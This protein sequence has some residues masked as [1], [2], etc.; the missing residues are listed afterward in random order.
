[1]RTVLCDD[2]RFNGLIKPAATASVVDGPWA[3][4]DTSAAGSPTV[5]TNNGFMELALDAT[6]EA[7][8][9]CLYF[10][11]QLP[12][13]IDDLVQVDIWA[14]ITASLPA[15]VSAAFGLASARNDAIDSIAAQALFRLIG[16][17]NLLVESDDGTTDK[18]DIATGLT[19]AATL[20]RFTISFK[21]G[22]NSVVGGLSTGGKSNVIFSAE[23]S[24][25]LLRRVA[26]ATRFDM[27]AYSSGL[28]PYFQIQKTAAASLG[29]LSIKRV[30][31][32]Y[33]G[34]E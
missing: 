19:L 23:N 13:D 26:P 32:Q 11:D 34:H 29:T 4:A 2:F 21:E 18:D 1:M 24:A 7:Q 20:R 16:D 10:G 3:K 5:Q 31:I 14:K 12:Y 15:A 6:N 33:R 27:S 8:N 17:N 9:L 22:I 25:G 30:R 28:Q